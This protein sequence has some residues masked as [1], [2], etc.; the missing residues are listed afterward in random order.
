MQ[1]RFGLR[2]ITGGFTGIFQGRLAYICFIRAL[3]LCIF[4]VGGITAFLLRFEFSIPREMLPALWVAIGVWAITKVLVFH[5]FG[6][7]RGMWRYFNTNDLVR[8]TKANVVSSAGAAVV[9][10]IGFHVSFPRSVLIVDFLVSMV[11]SAGVRAATRLALE[12]ASRNNA[13]RTNRAFIYGAGAGGALLLAEARLNGAFGYVVEGFIDDDPNKRGMLI[14]GV[15]VRGS[16]IDL[17]EL[18]EAHHVR[19]VLIAIPSA[20]GNQMTRIVGHCR[21]AGATFRTMPS[22]VEM[23]ADRPVARQI[24]DVAVEDILGREPVELDRVR[25]GGR[26]QGRIA[27]VT[28]AAGSIGSELCTQIARFQ[29]AALVAFE[30]S[31]S[32]LF[33]LER[34]IREKF[35]HLTFHA[36]IGSVQNVQRLREVFRRHS[37]SVVY[38][39]AAYKHVP[40]MEKHV[41]EAIENNII[42]TY[43]LAMVAAEFAVEDFVLISSDKAVRPTNIMG[44]TKRAAEL[45]IRSF[46]NG[47]PR[48][49]AVRFGNV[50]GSNGSVVPIFKKQIAAGGPVTVTH[51]DMQRYFMTIPEAA[52]LVLQASVMGRGGETF[53]LNMGD[54]VRI[55]DLARQL[56]LLSGLNPGEHIGIA[57]TGI[58]PGEKLCEEL[59]VSGERTLPTSHE[60]ISVF[61]GSCPRFEQVVR[62]LA[63][64]RNA[65]DTRD[66]GSAVLELQQ[67]VPDYAPGEEISER[68]AALNLAHL[69]LAH[70]DLVH[71][72]LAHLARAV[73]TPGLGATDLSPTPSLEES[74]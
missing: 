24:R 39:A 37:P 43:N 2:E 5:L 73:D 45:V 10:L 17:P 3:Q 31:E 30:I 63:H 67:M 41:L 16:G 57:F 51:P 12:V 22:L 49:V 23:V 74:A 19:T 44:A 4:F 68:L 13:G 21:Q 34:D 9:I 27:M 8:L 64:L 29:P 14:N 72:D 35:P 26:L 11:L 71:L 18:V 28:G 53:V 40:L 32:A 65:C 48:Y 20:T 25:I 62:H 61:S 33:H 58:R 1:G 66:V 70:L 50:L 36:E 52:Q 60:K 7:G 59:H 38:H 6:L 47:G 15:P 54:P 69:N 42:G 55:V 56:I 46:Q